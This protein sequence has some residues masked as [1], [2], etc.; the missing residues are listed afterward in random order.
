MSDEELIKGCVKGNEKYQFEVYKRYSPKMFGVCLR[1]C[2]NREE[3][4]DVLQDGFIK[5]FNKIDTF[6]FTGS[7][8]GWIRRIMIN[9]AIRNKYIHFRSHE[10]NNIDIIEPPSV[11]E[12]ITSD[13]S[14]TSLMKLV[15]E[16][17]HGYRIVFNM[18]AIEGYSHKEIS[19]MLQIQEATSR[20]QYLRA[21]K[22]LRDKLEKIE[23]NEFKNK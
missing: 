13:L 1:Y 4:Q 19:E 22:M 5:V 16:L 21:R 7:F 18:F 20:S 10:L 6:R 17:P 12:K 8:E 3:A 9:T 15:N 23:S 14:Y 11:D 2:A